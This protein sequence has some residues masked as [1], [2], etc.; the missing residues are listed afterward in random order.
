MGNYNYDIDKYTS[1]P[2]KRN[3]IEAIDN[4]NVYG[5]IRLIFEAM[6]KIF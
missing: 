6:S 4:I 3:K 1:F 5:L 2:A